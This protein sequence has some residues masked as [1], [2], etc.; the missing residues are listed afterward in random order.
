M[1]ALLIAESLAGMACSQIIRRG[2]PMGLVITGVS[3]KTG[4][5]MMGSPKQEHMNPLQNNASFEQ[6]EAEGAKTAEIVGRDE[7]RRMLDSYVQPPMP[8]DQCGALDE[9]GAK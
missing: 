1:L 5:P 2:A 3:M 9:F 8:D 6:W 7:A 4:A